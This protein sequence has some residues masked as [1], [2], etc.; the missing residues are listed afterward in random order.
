MAD[1]LTKAQDFLAGS[2]QSTTIT[3]RTIAPAANSATASK[4]MTTDEILAITGVSV[5]AIAVI[6]LIILNKPK[7]DTK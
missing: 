3:N 6:V 5:A 7:G 4:K 1:F 2:T